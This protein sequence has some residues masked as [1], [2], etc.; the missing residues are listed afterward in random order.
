M[1]ASRRQPYK[2][3]AEFQR[4]DLKTPR[5]APQR[6]RT[7]VPRAPTS[8]RS[9]S[10]P[11]PSNNVSTT[12]PSPIFKTPVTGIQAK[13][14]HSS[15][16][17]PYELTEIESYSQ[18]YYLG[19]LNRKQPGPV[20]RF[21]LNS[22]HY[23][24]QIGDHI[25]YRYETR[26]TLGKGAFGEVVRCFDHKTQTQ[27]AL[28]ILIDTPDVQVQGQQ[29]IAILQALKEADPT[30]RSHIVRITEHFVFRNHIC[31]V[32]EML[33]HNLY[34]YQRSMGFKPLDMKVVK[35]IA[36]QVLEALSFVHSHGYVHCDM[37]PENIL[38]IPGSTTLVKIADFGSACRIGAK[39]FDYIQSRF[40]RAPEVLLGIE[41]GPP[42]DMWSL[43]II[44]VELLTGNP[45][46]NGAS[47]NDQL[48]K[49][50]EVFGVPPKSVI[51][52]GK[53]SDKFFDDKGKPLPARGLKKAVS[54][55]ALQTITH[56]HDV[57]FLDFIKKC[58]E[59]DQTKRM[60]ASAA[61]TH[62]WFDASPKKKDQKKPRR[63]VL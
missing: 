16:L 17:A 7:A 50:M 20:P 21:E 5:P 1:R 19:R 9:T 22:R 53:R 11:D 18:V 3:G 15:L 62:K 47:E 13:R 36:K 44:L 24:F 45:M 57:R 35:G 61:L 29:E 37:K 58:F 4:I 30:D 43:G 6:P 23:N 2:V 63:S 26:A 52:Q 34:E 60:T 14:T 28:K 48:W 40:Y 8:A 41:Y 54:N 56:S 32:L 10:R 39:H 55:V 33:G 27:V 38:L 25:A 42:M 51:D 12:G 59:W 46:F 31:I 49:Y